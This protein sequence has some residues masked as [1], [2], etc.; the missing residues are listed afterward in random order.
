MKK[1]DWNFDIWCRKATHTIAY[2]PDRKRVFREL[3]GH[4]ED[5]YEAQIDRGCSPEEAEQM[6][7]ES[8]GSAQE[9]AAKMAAIYKPFWGYLLQASQ[10]VLAVLLVL[11]LIPI[12]KYVRAN[13][14]LLEPAPQLHN[15]DLYDSASY[16]GQTGRTLHHLSAPNTSFRS[17]G[18]TFTVTDAVVYTEYSDHYQ[19]NV[20][21]LYLQIRQQSLLPWQE[22]RQYSGFYYAVAHCFVR[23]AAGNE[24]YFIEGNSRSSF[25]AQGGIFSATHLCW[26]QDFPS[27]AKWAE[28][29]YERDGRSIAVRIDLTGGDRT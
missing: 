14:L 5:A 16:G 15:F 29:C 21:R 27:N 9:V 22:H 18:N 17:D 20:T 28:L 8:I 1:K 6:A 10:I 7:L 4:L 2:R 11:S 26:I 19:K 23:D 3:R 25:C 24:Y 12:L 13:A